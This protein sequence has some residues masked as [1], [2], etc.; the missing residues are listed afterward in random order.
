MATKL[1][2]NIYEQTRRFPYGRVTSYGRI[3]LLAGNPRA[4]RAVGFALHRNPEPGR[5]PCHRV[6]FRDGSL[7]SGF[8]FGGPEVQRAMLENEGV[9]FLPDGRVDMARCAWYG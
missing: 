3:A 1:T 8:A 2:Q 5:I 9:F 4:A 7:C 6:V